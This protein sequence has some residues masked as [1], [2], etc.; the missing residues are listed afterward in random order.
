MATLTLRKTLTLK[1]PEPEVKI[2]QPICRPRI[3]QKEDLRKLLLE[4]PVWVSNK[5][6][7]LTI[8][9]DIAKL[10][11]G[12][13]IG[14]RAISAVVYKH[15]RTE[16]YLSNVKDGTPRYNLDGSVN[17]C[18]DKRNEDYSKELIKALQSD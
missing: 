1:K 8:K 4:Q 15:V 12:L 11:K 13:E 3:E 10:V 9:D 17:G 2:V 6:L 18:C 16:E 5:P 14:T 7:A